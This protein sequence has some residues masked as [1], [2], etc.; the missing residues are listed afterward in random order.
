M[1]SKFGQERTMEE[2]TVQDIV[3]FT[4]PDLSPDTKLEIYQ[5]H[6]RYIL[7]F[8]GFTQAFFASS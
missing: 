4:V 8:Y 7:W 6:S 3:I 1:S 2:E 5:Q